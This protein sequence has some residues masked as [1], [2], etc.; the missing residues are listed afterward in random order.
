[1][2]HAYEETV[3]AIVIG[4]VAISAVRRPLERR[5]ETGVYGEHVLPI[6]SVPSKPG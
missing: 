6:L 3:V 5:S 1:M 4:R 2:L